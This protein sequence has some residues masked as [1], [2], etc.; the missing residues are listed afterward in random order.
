MLIWGPIIRGLCTLNELR[1]IYS[2]DDLCD[3]HEA[4]AVQDAIAALPAQKG[5]AR[6]D[7]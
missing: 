5:R 2:Y 1:T 7:P 6:H 4:M 3:M